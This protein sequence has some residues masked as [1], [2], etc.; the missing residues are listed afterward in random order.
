[1]MGIFAFGFDAI[2]ILIGLA[3]INGAVAISMYSL[4]ADNLLRFVAWLL[5]FWIY[6]LQVDGEENVPPDGPCVLVSNHVSFID[7]FVVMA[8]IRRPIR[9]VMYSQFARIPFLS[10]LFRQARVIPIPGG[11]E[12]P[13]LARRALEQIHREIADGGAV[14]IFPEGDITADGEMLPF[15][16]GIERLVNTDEPVPVVPMAL[17]G[18]WGSFFSRKNG[19]AMTKP[20]QRVWSEVWITI[21]EPIPGSQVTAAGLQAGCATAAGTPPPLAD[22]GGGR[23]V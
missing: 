15:R 5:S 18:L 14:C 7:W 23:R 12:R 2:D 10:F 17:N 8:A 9:F 22:R 3:I 11:R 16:R 4:V 13:L 21:G 6:R 20:F 1:M 19:R